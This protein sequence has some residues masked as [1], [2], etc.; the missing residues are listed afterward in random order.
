MGVLCA[1]L[2]HMCGLHAFSKLLE[3]LSL[4]PKT[5]V[6]LFKDNKAS[7]FQYCTTALWEGSIEEFCGAFFFF[8]FPVKAWNFL[9]WGAH[10]SQEYFKLCMFYCSE[11]FLKTNKD[12]F[13]WLCD[14]FKEIYLHTSHCGREVKDLHVICEPSLGLT[15][16][17][18]GTTWGW[19]GSPLL[20][21]LSSHSDQL[22]LSAQRDG[23]AKPAFLVCAYYKGH[24]GSGCAGC[25]THRY[26]D[27]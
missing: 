21:C 9:I 25:Q 14:Y 11:G 8:S 2:S 18:R 19:T 7:D 10:P 5:S 23:A 12:I 26:Q 24:P 6:N 13:Q 1:L 3:T 17:T 16:T 4:F 22:T 27:V 20:S 15:D